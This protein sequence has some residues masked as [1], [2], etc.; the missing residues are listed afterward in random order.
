VAEP[1]VRLLAA[2]D[3][4]QLGDLA[5]RA[6]AL[7]ATTRAPHACRSYRFPY[8][9]VA[10]HDAPVGVDLERVEPCDD[11]FARLTCTPAE[12][13]AVSAHA[14]GTTRDAFL[15]SLWSGKEAMAKA[16][17]DALRYEPSRLEAPLRW[18]AGRAGRWHA[19]AVDAVPA[20]HV[21]WLVWAA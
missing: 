9:L 21:G 20:G 10:W 11:A 16:L 19:R 7:A 6:R 13:A 12:R 18:P 2:R 17:G 3:G 15:T 14:P 1:T 8:A 4:E 5:T